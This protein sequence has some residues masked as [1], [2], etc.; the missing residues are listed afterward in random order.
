MGSKRA[1]YLVLSLVNGNVATLCECPV[2]RTY[3]PIRMS[4]RLDHFHLIH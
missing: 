2:E 3:R 4:D 1:V